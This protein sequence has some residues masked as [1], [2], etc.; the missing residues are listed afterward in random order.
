MTA[1]LAAGKA[2]KDAGLASIEARN[3]DVLGALRNLARNLA[4][5]RGEISI[6]DLREFAELPEDTTPLVFAAVFRG[7]DWE[8]CGFTMAAHPQAHARTVRLYR[9]RRDTWLAK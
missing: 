6:N 8:P 7:K 4:W 9:L 3:P 1:D 5:E 2:L